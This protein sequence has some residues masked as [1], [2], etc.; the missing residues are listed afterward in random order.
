LINRFRDQYL[1]MMKA[2]LMNTSMIMNRKIIDSR[3]FYQDRK[4]LGHYTC[5]LARQA[6]VSFLRQH[7]EEHIFLDRK[8]LDTLE[9]SPP[10]WSVIGYTVEQIIIS[11]LAT[12]G[13]QA[14]NAD[15][16]PAKIITFEGALTLDPEEPRVLYVPRNC[17]HEAVDA[18]YVSS[19]KD[20]DKGRKDKGT[21]HV[22]PIQITVRKKSGGHSRSKSTFF[23]N[24]T[25]LIE[26]F[27][28]R[29]V[30]VDA[31]FLWIVENRRGL[32]EVEQ[33]TKLLRNRTILTEP[34]HTE[35]SVTV[36][37]VHKELGEL[38]KRLRSREETARQSSK[39]GG[40]RGEGGDY[41]DSERGDIAKQCP[42]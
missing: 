29:G 35:E 26:D 42:A 9:F 6:M 31:S 30:P 10:N 14:G 15:I 41:K 8:W 19:H 12:S 27:R 25:R 38:L 16:Q 7:S 33:S 4:G 39:S 37:Q 40:R 21:V 34:K 24:W 23:A 36:G 13:L 1:P 22:I 32:V 18:V 5:G 17:D 28:K 2:C 20:M 11:A 3:Y